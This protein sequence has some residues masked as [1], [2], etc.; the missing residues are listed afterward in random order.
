MNHSQACSHQV[1][2]PQRSAA[3]HRRQTVE[4][5]RPWRGGDIPRLTAVPRG[6][7]R[8]PSPPGGARPTRPPP[9]T[10]SAPRSPTHRTARAVVGPAT[11]SVESAAPRGTESDRMF[12][13][14]SMETLL[15]GDIPFMLF[16]R[17]CAVKTLT[18]FDH[19][20]D[21]QILIVLNCAV[22]LNKRILVLGLR[23]KCKPFKFEN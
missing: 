21:R 22:L 11:D 7:C 4:N 17:V 23:H 9:G 18:N 16:R 1:T 2:I 8:D 20:F 15:F 5:R 12:E 14:L 10:P 3:K 19:S 13:T 6:V